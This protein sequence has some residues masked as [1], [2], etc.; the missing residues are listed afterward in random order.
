MCSFAVC[1]PT[2][3]NHSRIWWTKMDIIS[4]W[5]YAFSRTFTHV[6]HVD[7]VRLQ[8]IPIHMPVQKNGCWKWVT[9]NDDPQSS[10]TA[11]RKYVFKQN[12][13]DQQHGSIDKTNQVG[14]IYRH[15][16]WCRSRRSSYRYI[17]SNAPSRKRN[18][19]SAKRKGNPMKTLAVHHQRI[20]S[21]A[22]IAR[23]EQ[24]RACICVRLSLRKLRD[25][26]N[27]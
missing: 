3:T 8:F 19:Q 27:K 9:R 20:H 1:S 17:W 11:R 7:G 22:K 13:I 21:Y 16:L 4:D 2:W 26:C 12:G 14:F 18:V 5:K 25:A 23:D 15:H 10:V 24:T 6:A